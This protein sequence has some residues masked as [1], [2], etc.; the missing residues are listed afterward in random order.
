LHVLQEY[1]TG[2]GSYNGVCNF[3]QTHLN[4]VASRTTICHDSRT[5]FNLLIKEGE[6]VV[7]MDYT[8]AIEVGDE[9]PS[10]GTYE[11]Q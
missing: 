5:K 8:G 4:S 3:I 9:V 11:C 10:A 2:M 1:R 6:E 7:C